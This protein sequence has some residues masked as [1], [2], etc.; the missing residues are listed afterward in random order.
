MSLGK[1]KRENVP[2]RVKCKH[3]GIGAGISLTCS[4]HRRKLCD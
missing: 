4:R 1:N 3:K 2:D